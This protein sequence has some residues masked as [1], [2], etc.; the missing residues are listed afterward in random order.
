MAVYR[1]NNGQLDIVAGFQQLSV[2]A[3]VGSIIAYGGNTPPIGWLQ[4][5]GALVSRTRYADLFSIIGTTYGE[6]DGSTTFALPD[7]RGRTAVGIETDH[8][9]GT[10]EDGAL[11]NIT[12]T[13]IN[14]PT[15]HNL[16][17]AIRL[18]TGENEAFADIGASGTKVGYPSGSNTGG[19]YSSDRL[20]SFDASRCSSLYV[21]DQDTVVP[22]NVRIN[23]IIKANALA[24]ITDVAIGLKQQ[25]DWEH[26]QSITAQ[27]L[28]D[29]YTALADGIICT[30][31]TPANDIGRGYVSVN[32]DIVT[33]G[34]ANPSG[35]YRECQVQIQ[36]NE[37]D[38]VRTVTEN[39]NGQLWVFHITPIF[40]PFKTVA[41]KLSSSTPTESISLEDSYSTTE[42]KTNKIWIDG[43]TIYR[44]VFNVQ[45][46]QNADT[47]LNIPDASFAW[48]DYVHS[49]MTGTYG[50]RQPWTQVIPYWNGT[51][52]LLPSTYPTGDLT[53]V[54]EYIK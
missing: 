4:C 45:V 18:L 27:Q 44:K 43:R 24:D 47:V 19:S 26:A 38:V 10:S 49:F 32:G 21:N 13:F 22:A 51:G 36:V 41:V 25:P 20:Y 29:G 35:G 30:S 2:Y 23:Y 16:N 46:V 6:G 7:L 34:Y 9:L 12:S 39:N 14:S 1:N 50:Y 17:P 33:S 5:N 8:A 37:G 31:G 54:I 40:V 15:N 52:F 3:P 48:F 42:T 28:L 11:P 53:A